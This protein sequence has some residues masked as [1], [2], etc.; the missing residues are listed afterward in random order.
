MEISLVSPPLRLSWP[1]KRLELL[2]AAFP[3]VSRVAVLWDPTRLGTEAHFKEAE[4]A[5]RELKLHLESVEVRP[6]Y[7]FE[8]A[9]QAARKRGAQAL[10]INTAGMASHRVQI[11]NLEVKARLP[12]MHSDPSFVGCW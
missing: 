6:P 5:A 11:I 9:F 4:T 7:D 3:K 2:K 8:G 1:D 12:V 10:M